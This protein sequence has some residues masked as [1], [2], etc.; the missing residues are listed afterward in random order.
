MGRFF[1]F[2]FIVLL[3]ILLAYPLAYLVQHGLRAQYWP[4]GTIMPS[5]WFGYVSSANIG[6]MM[7]TLV[8]T[9]SFQSPSFAN[10]DWVNAPL[11]VF[12]PLATLVVHRFFASKPL[13]PQRDT[14]GT[15]GAARFADATER[16][17]MAQGLELGIDPDSGR[18]VRVAVQGTLVTFAPP[19]TGK[20]SGLLIPNLVYPE[21]GAWAGPAVVLDSKGEVHIATHARR[22]KLGRR[23]VC[24]D[25]LNLAGGK[26]RWNPLLKRDKTDIL[27]LQQ[28]ALALLPEAGGGSDEASSYFRIRAVDLIVGALIVAL[29]LPDPSVVTVQSMLTDDATFQD[30]LQRLDEISPDPAI[31]T[32]LDILK[33]DPKTKDPIKSTALQAFQWIADVRMRNLMSESTF[34]LAKLSENEIDIFVAMPPEYKR[35]LAPFLRW[36]LSELFTS[37]R[38]NRPHQ[39]VIVFVDEAAAL[40]RFDELLTASTELPGYGASIWTLWQD[41]SQVV[42]LYGEAGAS[43]LINTAEIV[44]LSDVSAVDPAESDRWS[45]A[46]GN[47]TAL[48]ESYSSPSTGQGSGTTNKAPQAAPLLSK[49][50]LVTMSSRQLLVFPNS[51]RSTRHPLQID[52]TVAHT[53]RRVRPFIQAVAPVGVAK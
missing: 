42:S 7:R 37:I 34:D 9:V 30:H 50:A 44:T 51:A 35:I 12:A 15:F 25:P 47:Y 1:Q 41:R 29:D 8:E 45:R 20:T 4:P 28:I 24:L 36:F 14:A 23:V 53:D 32:A 18:A 31:R 13:E 10:D 46:I 40:G 6:Q 5:T 52:K 19:R 38:R 3:T 43:T 49:E 33:S 27:A 17:H 16:A 22:A 48:I 26:D 21:L 11:L 39:R 2:I